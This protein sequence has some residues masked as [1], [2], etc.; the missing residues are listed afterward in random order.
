MH[1]IPKATSFHNIDESM[2]MPD[3][4]TGKLYNLFTWLF[5]VHFM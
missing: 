1:F 5:Q 4:E 3:K 2:T